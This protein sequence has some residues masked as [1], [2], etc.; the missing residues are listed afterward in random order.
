MSDRVYILRQKAVK[1]TQLLSSRAIRVTQQGVSAYVESDA[2]TGR[3]LR[4][5]LPYLP[6]DASDDLIAAIEGFLDHEVG[7]ILESDF[8]AMSAA[9]GH[10][11]RLGSMYNIIEDCR[12]EKA[13]ERRFAGSKFNLENTRTFFLAKYTTPKL[14]KARAMGDNA[15]AIGV[16]TVPLVRGLSGQQCM[17]DFIQ[18]H[19]AS[20]P[21]LQKV[22]DALAPFTAEL[23]ALKD[24]WEAL[25]LAKKFLKALHEPEQKPQSNPPAA[26]K[27]EG[28]DEGESQQAESGGKKK[29]EEDDGE[30]QQSGG[31]EAAEDEEEGQEGAGAAG[32]GEDEQPGDEGD[33]GPG[34]E[35]QDGQ[36][37]AGE[38][39]EDEGG[40]GGE[41]PQ[42]A[43]GEQGEA[44]GA[45]KGDEEDA[46]G[47]PTPT[48]QPNEE[49]ERAPP[50]GAEWD[51]ADALPQDV[52]EAID[53]E[54][55]NNYDDCISDVISD[56]TA[57]EAADADYLVF[58]NDRDRIEPLHVGHEYRPDML[59]K[60]EDDVLHMVGP[61]QKDLERAI[62]ARSKII[63]TGGHRSGQ[64][65]A[66]ALARLTV[67]TPNGFDDRVFYR[68][69]EH[70]SKDVAVSLVD[71]CSG[72]MHGSKLHTAA[73][74]SYA[75]AMTLERIGIP[76]EV[77]G[78]TTGDD[79][80]FDAKKVRE[81]EQKMG[82][83]YS[84]I[85]PIYMPIL[86]DF[87]ERL[88]TEV[89]QRFAWLPNSDIPNCNIDGES[90]LFASHRLMK[91]RE[92]QKVMIVLSDGFPAGCGGTAKL[93]AHLKKVVR[94]LQRKG[95]KMV[96]IGIESDA[97]E[98][99]YPQH[100]VMRDV[101]E[102]PEI[103]MKQLRALVVS[104]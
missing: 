19:L 33:S 65:H 40:A 38:G 98:K 86:K 81:E 85:E 66:P 42:Q 58:S 59:K 97:V 88:T 43:S 2:V 78:F 51:L 34:D 87:N 71:D 45:A 83:E 72:S 53:A 89:K 55:A 52:L 4:V 27:Q 101:K 76:C 6:D 94:D 7:H 17:M 36:G 10:K 44:P 70:T 79:E 50:T 41:Q 61:M 74:A 29:G 102:L 103:V 92:K 37:A 67:R 46:P 16:L 14:E 100:V 82:A 39:E 9:G 21:L 56:S 28:G 104:Q 62:A 47:N 49:A 3:P 35:P 84:R 12:M 13:M 73:R 22:H 77:L 32:E 75:L 11:S 57:M 8:K 20:D 30:E 18:P 91:R 1:L 60:L 96:G 26:L 63:R 48:D 93:Q 69:Q 54:T 5:N 23:R 68:L 90:V 64:L 99:F 25:E 31:A 15:R 95:I 80:V 24:S